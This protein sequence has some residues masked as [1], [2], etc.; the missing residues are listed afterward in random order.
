MWCWVHWSHSIRVDYIS[1][2]MSLLD[3][4]IKMLSFKIIFKWKVSYVPLFFLYKSC[5]CT[6][7]EKAIIW[8]PIKF[9]WSW[10]NTEAITLQGIGKQSVYT[11]YFERILIA[12]STPI[13]LPWY[14][15]IIFFW[16]Q[17]F[18]IPSQH[19]W[20]SVFSGKTGL[21]IMRPSFM[22]FFGWQKQCL[23]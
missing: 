15:I 16:T 18:H 2:N 17:G 10:Y 9:P 1:K 6:S 8:L 19:F 21:E 5:V 23:K 20:N 11:E 13:L 4:Q 12:L 14:K 22:L 7:R 3:L